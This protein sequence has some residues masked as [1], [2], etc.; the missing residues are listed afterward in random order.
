M[1]RSFIIANSLALTFATLR[2]ILLFVNLINMQIC[3]ILWVLMFVALVF[4]ANTGRKL[5][6]SEHS[7]TTPKEFNL[8][9]M[10]ISI[11]VAK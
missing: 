3:L 1:S 8:G 11:V 9:E 4:G 5:D 2:V 10:T 6:N 7:T